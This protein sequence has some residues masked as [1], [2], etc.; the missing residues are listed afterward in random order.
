MNGN[1]KACHGWG[2]A[3]EREPPAMLR[4]ALAS[5]R[6][7]GVALLALPSCG[8]EPCRWS[9]EL[10]ECLQRGDCRGAVL[11]CHDIGLA[12]CVTNKVPGV[13]AAPA[14]TVAQ[15]ERALFDLGANLLIAELT[16]RTFYEFKQL[17]RLGVQSRAACPPGVACVLRCRA[18]IHR[19]P[20]IAG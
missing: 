10:A 17:L 6:R 11:F 19:W 2:Y 3:V 13:R 7:E 16:G 15:A 12:C 18:S 1:G 9:R 5:L 20:A 8:G 14:W 4:F